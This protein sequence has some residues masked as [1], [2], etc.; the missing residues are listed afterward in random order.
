M[1]NVFL[2]SWFFI[3]LS[4]SIS[5]LVKYDFIL[6][7][8]A[9]VNVIRASSFIENLPQISAKTNRFPAKFAREAPTKSAILCQSF[10]S[11]TGLENSRK[12]PVKSAI[13]S[14]N[15][16]LKIPR[17]LTF[18]PA[19]YQKPWFWESQSKLQMFP[20]VSGRHIHT[21]HYNFQWYPLSNNSSSEYRT[22]PELLHVVYL[23][24]F[25]D[26]WIS[27][28]NLLNGKRFYFSLAW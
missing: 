28:L 23:L 20:L 27:W 9:W 6:R 3:C 1:A 19:T 4:C 25:Y 26:I 13:F 24:L 10:F 5:L 7:Y 2:I 21:K 17:N 11:E 12:I 18:F 14:A 22:S 15:L 16:S 8:E